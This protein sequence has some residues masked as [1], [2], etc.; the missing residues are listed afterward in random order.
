MKIYILTYTNKTFLS[1]DK[2]HSGI[3]VAALTQ[4]EVLQELGHNVRLFAAQTDLDKI[5]NNVDYF[6][7]EKVPN[8]KEYARKNKNNIE[9]K[10]LES[11][12]N[13]N[14][15]II[16]S[17]YEFNKFYDKLQALDI[18]I[19]YFSH[20]MPGF[21]QDFLNANLLNSMLK[22]GHSFG[23]VSEYHKRGIIKYYRSKRSIWEFDEIIPDCTLAP[24]YCSEEIVQESDGTIRHCSAASKG[25]DTFLILDYLEGT[26]KEDWTEVFTTFGFLK[27][28]KADPYIDGALEKYPEKIKIDVVH[29]EILENIGKSESV[30]VGNYP[31]T[32][33]ITS[34]EA[35]GRGVPLIVKDKNG[36]PA[37]EMVPEEFLN[38]VQLIKN[39]KDFLVAIEKFKGTTLEERKALANAVQ[40]KMN[41][42][43]YKEKFQNIV[44]NVQE[45][46]TA[47]K[48]LRSSEPV[49][50]EEW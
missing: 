45:K 4:M 38:Y 29:K 36:H 13:F 1:K 32:F 11:I 31:D 44:L 27:K 17:N 24:Q 46:Y 9:L 26:D 19:L 43:S 48:I 50:S 33:T 49:Q 20:A 28:D 12:H 39:K 22:N 34:L 41:K 2:K 8:T 37:T 3:D 25:K 5:N 30:F 10:I 14:P 6:I 47:N 16:I 18:P 42:E 35:L 40:K 15:D 21:W 23:C 7:N